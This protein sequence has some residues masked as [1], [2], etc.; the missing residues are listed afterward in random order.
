M[1]SAVDEAQQ[2]L[3]ET[4]ARLESSI[5]KLEERVRHELDWKS[6]LRRDGARYAV[7]GVASLAVLAALLLLRSRLRGA[8][9]EDEG[10]T[11]TGLDDIAAELQALRDELE[12]VRKGKESQPLWQKAALRALAAAGTA[13][14]T[15]VARGLMERFGGD[16]A[17]PDD[18]EWRSTDQ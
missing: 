5:D 13:A 4:K 6:R 14:G 2:E 8:E 17:E 16:G 10:L 7:I 12:K 18:D 9:E 1:G 3:D 15:A 11:V